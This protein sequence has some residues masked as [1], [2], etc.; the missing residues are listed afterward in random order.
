MD[1]NVESAEDGDYW[2]IKNV[3]GEYY[4]FQNSQSKKY[5]RHN[6]QASS[7]REALDLVDNIQTDN[8]TYFT[9]EL[10]E[11]YGTSYYVIRSV[12]NS[13]KIWNK[14]TSEHE[15][16]YPMGVYGGT[17]GSNELFLFVDN[18]G[19][20]VKDDGS[21]S[22]LTK[23]DRSLGVFDY[24]M[25][26]LKINGKTPALNSS[27]GWFG[28]ETQ[29]FVS[30]SNLPANN[31]TCS[32]NYEM[33][34]SRHKLFV[35][36]VQV[37]SGSSFTIRKATGTNS[38]RI[39]IVDGIT[40]LEE[41]EI[42]FTSLPIVQLYS[43]SNIYTYYNYGFISVNEADSVGEPKILT[44]KIRV[45]G[46]TSSGKPKK[47]YAINIQKPDLTD[48]E[49]HTF[50]GLRSDNS[51]IMDAMYIDPMRM[52]N[53]VSFDLWNDFSSKPYWADKEENMINGTRGVF[54]EAFLNDKYIGLYCMTEKVDRKQLKLKKIQ[55]E[56]NEIEG[57]VEYTQRGGLYKAKGWSPAVMFGYPGNVRIPNFNNYYEPW[58]TYE[59]KYPKLKDNLPI[60]W[61]NLH[62]AITTASKYHTTDQKF[63]EN[64]H[65]TFDLPV[66]LDYFLFIELILATDNHGKNTYTSIYNQTKSN[67]VTITPW[68][69]DGTW[70]IRW[71]GSKHITYAD[72][73]FEDFISR[74]E[75]GRFYLFD[76]L[77]E[78]DVDGWGTDLLKN[79]YLQLRRTH[80]TYDNLMHY[81]QEYEKQFRLSGA[82]ERERER[83]GHP[84]LVGEL[85]FVGD[86]IQARL[87]YLDIQYLGKTVSSVGAL[88]TYIKVGPN[89]VV[90]FVRVYDLELGSDLQIYN[91]QGALVYQS[92]VNSENISVD[93]SGYKS[94]IYLLKA[95]NKSAKF[96]KQ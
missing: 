25:S 66:Y 56:V 36:G 7:D 65:E 30:V 77:K 2:I 5:I 55:E 43:E 10:N 14:R 60:M 16:V 40:T 80:F 22:E 54:V 45:R 91:M 21:K 72:Q 6:P 35:D 28:D 93:M 8:S 46:A 89:P 33:K 78:L 32:V 48:K 3:E 81:F 26:E 84:D 47:S 12:I 58:E 92:I 50:F 9:L 42:V 57:T 73:N 18:D 4:T 23:N 15:G 34:N 75:H 44:T 95:G 1:K 87:D 41:G 63:L 79:R 62:N 90:D 69:L 27:S 76:R 51:W 31:L 71:D 86:W 82:G 19:D 24:Y 88:D 70:G 94:G 20:T 61:D 52:R 74:H 67:K 85:N 11:Q 29:F 83:W 13:S 39:E 96:I 64:V 49:N 37:D 17:G 68:D 53:R 59:S 38:V